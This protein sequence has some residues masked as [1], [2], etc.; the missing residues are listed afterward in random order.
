MLAAAAVCSSLLRPAL[1]CNMVVIRDARIVLVAFVQ[2]AACGRKQLR[3]LMAEQ[4][5][6]A[7]DL[8]GKLQVRFFL[9]LSAGLGLE[10]K[11][12]CWLQ[13]QCAAVCCHLQRNVVVG[14]D[15]IGFIQQACTY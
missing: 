14:K 11:R 12:I 5:A 13:L 15:G 6:L 1:H 9:P 2:Q 7:V 10:K 8:Y 4:K 3:G